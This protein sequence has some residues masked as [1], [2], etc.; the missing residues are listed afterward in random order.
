[1]GTVFLDLGD[2]A[3]GEKYILKAQEVCVESGL[4][5]DSL[6]VLPFLA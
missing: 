2:A 6:I 3:Q 1:L 4:D 5:P